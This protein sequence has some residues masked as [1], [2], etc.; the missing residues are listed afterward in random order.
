MGRK[1]GWE[2]SRVA[3]GVPR[4]ESSEGHVPGGLRR[5]PVPGMGSFGT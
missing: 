2:W 5:P 3:R 4:M 1:K